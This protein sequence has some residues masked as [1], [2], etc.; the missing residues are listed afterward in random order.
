VPAIDPSQ[1]P[2]CGGAFA[3]ML[4]ALTKGRK[5]RRREWPH[6]RWTWR[7]GSAPL[8]VW[9][10]PDEPQWVCAV[11]FAD[12]TATDWEE[13]EPPPTLSQQPGACSPAT[14]PCIMCDAVVP[15]PKEMEPSFAAICARCN[16]EADTASDLTALRSQLAAGEERV[17]ELQTEL[18]SH[19][20]QEVS[21]K[22]QLAER[23]ERVAALEEAGE[24]MVTKDVHQAVK[25]L[26]RGEIYAAVTRAKAAEEQVYGLL[27]KNTELLD[28]NA[29]IHAAKESLV[30]E[31]KWLRGLVERWLD[32]TS[33]WP[34]PHTGQLIEESEKAVRE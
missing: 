30:V 15:V 26:L 12:L 31:V 34:R 22:M 11:D 24:M 1:Q 19:A 17:A 28:R 29:N 5:A 8:E 16:M 14:V 3:D 10:R 25:D 9:M 21:W 32:A 23:N 13:L 2:A 4:P 33:R 20:N 6:G 18:E 7:R 27:V